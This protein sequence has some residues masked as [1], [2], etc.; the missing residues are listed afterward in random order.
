MV[1]ER[2]VKKHR[3]GA[4]AVEPFVEV[5][6][7]PGNVLCE[8]VAISTLM[9]SQQCIKGETIIRVTNDPTTKTFW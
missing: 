3:L 5:A 8:S 6:I 2:T 4:E 1:D 9:F 7:L